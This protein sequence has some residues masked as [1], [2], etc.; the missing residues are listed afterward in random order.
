MAAPYKSLE[1]FFK[2]FIKDG[3]DKWIDQGVDVA[4]PRQKVS[5]LHWRI[6]R[7]ARVNDYFL[8]KKR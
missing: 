8:D 3:V 5:H 1:S 7:I 6:A 4:Q 2:V